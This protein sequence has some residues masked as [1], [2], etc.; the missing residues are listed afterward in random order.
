MGGTSTKSYPKH[1]HLYPLKI[2][3]FC[4]DM[5]NTFAKDISINSI[6][7]HFFTENNGYPID[8]MCLQR[9]NSM[10]IYMD[11][12]KTF[13]NYVEEYNRKYPGATIELFYYPYDHEDN[14]SMSSNISEEYDT[15]S[16]SDR[17][18]YDETTYGKLIVSRYE[19]V[20]YV[21]DKR[22]NDR[23]HDTLKNYH[24]YISKP[25]KNNKIQVLNISVDNFIVSIYNLD[26]NQMDSPMD[27][28][29]NID[30]ILYLVKA[31]ETEVRL[32]CGMRDRY[33]Y[34]SLHIMCG[35]IGLNEIQNNEMNK[36]YVK[37]V[38][39]VRTVDLLRYVTGMRDQNMLDNIYNTNLMFTRDNFVFIH[40][41]T[42]Q[43]LDDIDELGDKI[44]KEYGIATI[45][46]YIDD[47]MDSFFMNYPTDILLLIDM[48]WANI[49]PDDHNSLGRSYTR[50]TNIEISDDVIRKM[51]MGKHTETLDNDDINC[52]ESMDKVEDLSYTDDSDS[53]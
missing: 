25:V 8:V 12:I 32:H 19:S 13:K 42:D 51:L 26:L 23:K 9:I 41:K 53:Y 17:T 2:S 1:D 24:D 28:E 15:W 3:S 46:A 37:F 31:N 48:K 11:I 50:Y 4:V 43:K 6:V 5:S 38:K 36:Q 16:L 44:Y 14:S 22:Y 10:D 33:D 29:E 39:S 45:D 52:S 35:M 20:V 34:R 18:S 30:N 27:I 49:Y 40:T 7:K 47:K 21:E